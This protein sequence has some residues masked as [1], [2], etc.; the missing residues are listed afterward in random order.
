VFGLAAVWRPGGP[1]P[2]PYPGTRRSCADPQHLLRDY[3]LRIG[4][5]TVETRTYTDP[6]IVSAAMV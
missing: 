5:K 4:I 2:G 1:E 6:E 3:G